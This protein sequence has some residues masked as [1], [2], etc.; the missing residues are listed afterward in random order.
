MC[1]IFHINIQLCVC[2][3]AI[4]D[5]VNFMLLNLAWKKHHVHTYTQTQT[6]EQLMQLPFV[7]YS[8][9]IFGLGLSTHSHHSVH[10]HDDDSVRYEKFRTWFQWKQRLMNIPGK[11]HKCYNFWIVYH[12]ALLVQHGANTENF[13]M[14]SESVIWKIKFVEWKHANHAC[15]LPHMCKYCIHVVLVNLELMCCVCVYQTYIKRIN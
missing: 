11:P 15:S 2:S 13:V 12:H 14:R 3:I 5:N 9:F 8:I 7:E 4:D 10:N 1:H 6:F